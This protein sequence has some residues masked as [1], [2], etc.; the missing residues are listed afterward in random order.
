MPMVIR[1]WIEKPDPLTGSA[2]ADA[3]DPIRFEGWMELLR[4]ISEL[5]SKPPS[6]VG[7]RAPGDGQEK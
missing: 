2:A 3:C 1:I 4:A 6:A 5:V 7:G